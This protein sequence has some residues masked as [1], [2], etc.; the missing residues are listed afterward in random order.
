MINNKN[1]VL[2]FQNAWDGTLKMESRK[3]LLVPPDDIPIIWVN[4]LH[5]F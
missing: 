4:I 1:R 5:S 2:A 3:N